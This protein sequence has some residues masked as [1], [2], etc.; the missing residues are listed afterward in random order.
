MEPFQSLD[1]MSSRASVVS[2]RPSVSSRRESLT[3]PRPSMAYDDKATL[4]RSEDHYHE[5]GNL[6][7]IA[8]DVKFRVYSGMLARRSEVFRDMF[9]MPQPTSKRT[10]SGSFIENQQE[11][12]DGVPAIRLADDPEGITHL[13]DLVLPVTSP[14]KPMESPSFYA[15]ESTLTLTT[16]YMF[17]DLREWALSC[18]LHRFPHTLEEVAAHPTLSVYKDPIVVARLINLARDNCLD[19]LLPMAFYAL[20]VHNWSDNVLDCRD[21]LS[22]LSVDDQARITVGRLLMQ[23][24]MLSRA[25]RMPENGMVLATCANSSQGTTSENPYPCSQYKPQQIWGDMVDRLQSLIRDPIREF[26]IRIANKGKYHSLCASC[27]AAVVKGAEDAR[28]E[29]FQMLPIFFHL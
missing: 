13:L 15:L 27:D 22:V 20:A 19:Q 26:G 4:S 2:P 11:I 23:D 18:L 24:E 5:D 17:D 8:G 9:S 7:L 10:S 29:I 6:I 1:E 14:C 3:S 12:V 21:A 25:T 16:K 28:E